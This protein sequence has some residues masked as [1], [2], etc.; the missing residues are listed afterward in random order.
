MLNEEFGL[1]FMPEVSTNGHL[2]ARQA[3]HQTLP[4]SPDSHPA[5][6]SQKGGWMGSLQA[7]GLIVENH[8][9]KTMEI[10]KMICGIVL[11]NE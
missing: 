3:L 6:I 5:N 2:Q 10:M 11:L 7:G 9:S 4:F 8:L 1:I